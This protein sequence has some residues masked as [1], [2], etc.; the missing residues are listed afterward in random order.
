LP[1]RLKSFPNFQT[2]PGLSPK[3][4]CGRANYIVVIQPLNDG[5]QK[6]NSPA[7]GLQIKCG[8]EGK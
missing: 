1:A 6:L 5:V 8:K 4:R 7:S 2:I 3:T